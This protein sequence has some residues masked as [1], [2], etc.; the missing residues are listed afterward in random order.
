MPPDGPDRDEQREMAARERA[1]NSAR[2]LNHYNANVAVN[3][4]IQTDIAGYTSN[5]TKQVVNEFTQT[6]T[7]NNSYTNT[8]TV[9]QTTATIESLKKQL[10]CMK[11]MMMVLTT[12][13]ETCEIEI[14]KLI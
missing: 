5:N 1:I 12:Q 10:D 7:K 11:S 2:A 9:Q 6:P 4:M 14:S 8:S 3:Y 13:I